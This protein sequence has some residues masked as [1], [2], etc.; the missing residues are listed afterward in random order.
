MRYSKAGCGF[1]LRF[2][3]VTPPVVLF[4]SQINRSCQS[5]L[6][7]ESTEPTLRE[8]WRYVMSNV[9]ILWLFILSFQTCVHFLRGT[10]NK[11]MFQIKTWGVWKSGVRGFIFG[12][13]LQYLA[14]L[15]RLMS[16]SLYVFNEE[17]VIGV[18][19]NMSVIK[20]QNF[21]NF[22]VVNPL[23]SL[24]WNHK[25]HTSVHWKYK[26]KYLTKYLTWAMI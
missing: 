24:K 10:Q 21:T 12:K 14:S 13:L 19:N 23:Q 16:F 5:V 18:W 26:Q 3:T 4:D 25:Q 7:N 9:K 17:K 8:F 15:C 2:C 6:F 11:T 1:K 20:W 22:M